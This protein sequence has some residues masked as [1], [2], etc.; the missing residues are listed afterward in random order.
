MKK[1]I[2]VIGG[3]ASGMTASIAAARGGA[4]VILLEHRERVGKKILST[5][6]GRCNMTNRFQ[7]EGCYRSSDGNDAFSVIRRF[8]WEETVLFFRG[9]G[10]FGLFG[11]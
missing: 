7:N 4:S 2:V 11:V 1:R 10:C 8:G 9:L 3:G 5:G 6:N